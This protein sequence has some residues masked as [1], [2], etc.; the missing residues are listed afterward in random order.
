M[1][2]TQQCSVNL[3]IMNYEPNVGFG[4]PPPQIN[5]EE[6]EFIRS[7]RKTFSQLRSG[8]SKILNKYMNRID[9]NIE[10][11]CPLCYSGPHNTC[12]LFSFHK[13][14]QI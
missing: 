14:Q 7:K 1:Y 12:H 6:S 10:I 11:N 5:E 8:C 2:N 13:T 4:T 3:T 9:S